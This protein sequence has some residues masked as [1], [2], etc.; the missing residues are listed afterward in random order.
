MR[1]FK[2]FFSIWRYQVEVY[3]QNIMASVE[4]FFFFVLDYN[5]EVSAFFRFQVSFEFRNINYLV[6]AKDDN[7]FSDCFEQVNFDSEDFFCFFEDLSFSKQL[8][9][10]VKEEFAEEVEEEAFEVSVVFKDAGFSADFGLWFCE[11]CGKIFSA[12]KQLERYQ[13]FLCFVKFFICYVC[14]KVFRINFRFWSYFQSYMFQVVEDSAYKDSDAC[15]VFI[16]FSSSSFLFLLSSLFKIQFLEFDSFTG[17][18]ENSVFFTEKLFAFQELDTFFYYVLFLLV[19][20]FKR[21]FMC[22]FC[23][24]IFKTAFSFWSYE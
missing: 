18:L 14:N 11:K 1:I 12:Y 15:F 24:R 7:V 5:G 16:N 23:Y 21:Q 9:I 4:N 17:L 3:N 6:V 10:Q 8:K 13:E 19:I 22:K 2:F 20:I